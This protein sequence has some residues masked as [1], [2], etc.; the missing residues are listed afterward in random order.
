MHPNITIRRYPIKRLTALVLVLGLF[1]LF[2]ARISYVVLGTLAATIFNVAFNYYYSRTLTPDLNFAVSNFRGKKVLEMLSSGIWNSITQLSQILTSGLDLLITNLLLGPVMMG[3][4]SVAKTV[5]NVI[6]TFN[7]TIGGVFCPNLM[8]LYAEGDREG[9]KNAAKSAMRFMC[10]FV[11]IP[12]AIVFTMGREFFGIWVPTEPSQMLHILAV[13]TIIN[14]CISGPLQ[15]IYQ[16]FTI[17]NKV[18]ESSLVMIGY[19]VVNIIC[20]YIALRLTN[21]GVY[22][23]SGISLAGALVV[24]L[25]YHVP[26]S[27]KYAGLSKTAFVP[28]I[29]KSV[30]S[31]VIVI[32]VG[33]GVK[34]FVD[35]SAGWI[36]WFAGAA[37]TAVIGFAVNMAIVL[38]REERLALKDKIKRHLPK[39]KGA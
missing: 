9:L 24:A 12:N 11:S 7:S 17:T 31:L 2:E 14:S 29:L 4:M 21:W 3:H 25:A 35:I 33:Y 38:N 36:S 20:V 19:G 26:Y 30:L 27:A 23:V 18:K 15:P 16:I 22:A 37:I 1:F 39:G 13:L 34:L 8:R 10:L 32:L 5:P 28:E 6:I